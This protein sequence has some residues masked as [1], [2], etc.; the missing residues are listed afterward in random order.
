MIQQSQK[1]KTEK[2]K[3]RKLPRSITEEV[4]KLLNATRK[5]T[6]WPRN[7]A[8]AFRSNLSFLIHR[9]TNSLLFHRSK[10]SLPLHQ[11]LMAYIAV[12]QCVVAR[13]THIKVSVSA[14]QAI[15]FIWLC[16]MRGCHF[17]SF[18]FSPFQAMILQGPSIFPI[19]NQ[20]PSHSWNFYLFIYLFNFDASKYSLVL[21]A[22]LWFETE[23]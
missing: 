17:F 19:V 18:W 10:T 13:K 9:S 23:F 16:H 3:N 22:L 5:E 8:Y 12:L 2:T 4:K 15:L 6:T 11:Q 21:L 1:Q 14:T 20:P 7:S